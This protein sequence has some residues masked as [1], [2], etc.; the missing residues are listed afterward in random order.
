[1]LVLTRKPGQFILLG[2]S[3]QITV[4]KVKGQ[5]IRLG[6]EAPESVPIQRGELAGFDDQASDE[7]IP[8]RPDM[9]SAVA[10][11]D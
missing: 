5:Q 6:I 3:V 10:V 9:E 2:D 11:D 1:M 4:V 7:T 8:A